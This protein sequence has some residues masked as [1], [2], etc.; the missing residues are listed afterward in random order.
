[1]QHL[2]IA[3]VKRDLLALSMAQTADVGKVCKTWPPPCWRPVA[4]TI[5][6]GTRRAVRSIAAMARPL[7]AA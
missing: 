3:G 2:L 5:T 1:M 4:R 6:S 7:T